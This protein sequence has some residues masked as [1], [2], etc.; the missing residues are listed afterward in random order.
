MKWNLFRSLLGAVLLSGSA[1]RAAAPLSAYNADPASASVSGLS[2]GGFMAAQLGVAYSN[3]F[4]TGFGVFAGGPYDCARNQN[5]TACMYNATPAIATPVANMK[6]WSGNQIDATA[7]LASRRIYLWVGSSDTTVGPNVEGQLKSQ[8]GN[9]DTAGNVSYVVSSGA[10]HTFP[11]DFSGAG[12]NSCSS[13]ASPYISNCSYDGAGAALQWMYGTL[14]ARNNGTLGGSVV[15]FDQTAFVSAG[16]GMDSTG[17]LYVPRAC[18]PGGATVCKVHVALH[19]CQQSVS[20]IQQ[21]FINNTGYNKWADTNNI[22]IVYPQAIPDNTS[23]QTWTSGSLPNGNGCWDWIGWYGS[24]ADQHGGVQMAAIVAMVNRITSGYVPGGGGGGGVPAVPAGLTVTGTTTSSASLSW[25][26]AS[27]ATSYNV[28]RGSTRVGS[29]ASTSFTDSGLAASTSYTYSVT[30]VNATGESAHSAT[31]TA[32]TGG[33]YTP[34]CYRASNYAHVTAGRA[35]DSGGY[36]LANGSNQNLGLDNVYYT[37]TLEE[38]APNYYV[39]NNG[40]CP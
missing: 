28:Y 19:G 35:H 32:T 5:Y 36:A 37:N 18:A 22:I 1:A 39:I 3:T 33:G 8:L 20:K 10:A 9:F 11:T 2:S 16:N 40:V 17:Y 34:T 29:P 14:G 7:N 15:A 38:T 31:V 6:S 12:D 25:S 26:A 13:A 27:G 4:R 21:T 24:N 30:G 23:H